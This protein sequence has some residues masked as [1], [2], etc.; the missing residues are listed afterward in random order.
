MDILLS[1]YKEVIMLRMLNI[2]NSN[3]YLNI[4]IDNEIDYYIMFYIDV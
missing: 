1:F 2:I 3:Y 4:H